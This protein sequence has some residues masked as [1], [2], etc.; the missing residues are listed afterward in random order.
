MAKKKL[1]GVI[2]LP[3]SIQYK[4]KK[5]AY[6]ATVIALKCYTTRG[7]YLSCNKVCP[8]SVWLL[9]SKCNMYCNW[10]RRDLSFTLAMPIFTESFAF[11]FLALMED[12]SLLA[13]SSFTLSSHHLLGK[14]NTAGLGYAA[15]HSSLGDPLDWFSLGLIPTRLN[16]KRIYTD[17]GVLNFFCIAFCLVKLMVHTFCAKGEKIEWF[18]KILHFGH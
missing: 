14:G 17:G 16:I 5:V 15:V 8:M 18:G 11:C 9:Y 10:R 13:I 7:T 4:K 1:S 2:T 3:Y 12:L 6:S